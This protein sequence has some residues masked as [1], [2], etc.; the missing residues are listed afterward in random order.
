M[1]TKEYY[2]KH[3]EKFQQAGREFYWKNREKEL[4]LANEYNHSAKG[5]QKRLDTN[6]IRKQLIN[7]YKVAHGCALCGVKTL[8]PECYDLHHVNPTDK[9]FAI[10]KVRQ[11]GSISKILGEMDKCVVLCRNCHA[12]VSNGYATVNL[13]TAPDSL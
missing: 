3:K 4:R 6:H 1:P 8:P 9:K 2:E 5:Q 10:S 12:L 11:T 7:E 13:Y